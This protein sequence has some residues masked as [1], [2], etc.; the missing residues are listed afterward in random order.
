MK[1]FI[2]RLKKAPWSFKQPLTK[3]PKYLGTPVSD[4][5]VWRNSKDW[6]T[7]FELTDIAGMFDDNIDI[8]IQFAI[9]C[10][11]DNKGSLL[12]EEKL[13]LQR[14]KRTTIDFSQFKS[15]AKSEHGT[16]CIFHSHTPEEVT[17]LGSFLTERGYVSYCYKDAPLRS[18]VH[19]NLDAIAQ[20]PDGVR[21]LLGTRSLLSRKYSLQHQLIGPANYEIG[22]VNS[23]S[24]DISLACIVLSTDN[25]IL[26][27]YK[28]VIPQRGICMFPVHLESQKTARIVI[29]SHLVM[30]RPLIFR[31]NNNNMDVFHG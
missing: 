26:N 3:M 15:L 19:G 12:H 14:N 20:Y 16:F 13:K 25:E 5:F 10:L 17:G 11:F 7:F 4:L 29:K 24:S 31:T 1:D 22:I 23:T 27:I 18:Y 6:N 8:K 9:I 2:K 28:S 21:H 30:A